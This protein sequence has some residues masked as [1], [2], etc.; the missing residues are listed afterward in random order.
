MTQTLVETL[1]FRRLNDLCLV[2][3]MI[4]DEFC[5]YRAACVSE[6]ANGKSQLLLYDYGRD[7]SIKNDK[8]REFPKELNFESLTNYCKVKGSSN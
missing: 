4:D 2:N 6:P 7:I 3:A 8:I 5:W 1:S